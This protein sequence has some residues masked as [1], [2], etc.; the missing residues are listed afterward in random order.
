MNKRSVVGMVLIV[1]LALSL[2]CGP[3]KPTPTVEVTPEKTT[4]TKTTEPAPTK[5]T[6]EPKDSGAVTSLD[7]VK[8][9]T[10][11]IEAEGVFVD[12]QGTQTSSAGRGSGFIIDP[13]GIAVTNNHVVAGA[14]MLRVW[15]GGETEPRNAK[16]LG[17]SECSDLA[18]IDLEGN[19][20][21]YL[22]PYTGKATTGLDVYAAGFPLGDP[23]FT[24][25]RGII[26]K[27]RANGDTDWASVKAVLEHDAVINPGNSGGP[28]V[29]KD[30]E[31]VGVN[32]ASYR[33][34]QQSFAI[35]WS[36][37]ADIVEALQT[38]D[39][40]DSLGVNAQAVVLEDGLS[41]VWAAS[42]QPGSS[43]D[44]AGVQSGDIIVSLEN[45]DL[46]TDG[47]MADY[48]DILRTHAP[49]DTLNV[50][51]VR[52]ATE[53]MWAGQINGREL[54]LSF[55]FAQQGRDDVE[56]T[57]SAD[58][59]EEY[60]K[61]EDESSA[62]VMEVPAEWLDQDGGPWMNDDE[63][64]GASLS[65][66]PDLEEFRSSYGTPGVF[67][68]AAPLSGEFD[69]DGLLDAV[70]EQESCTYEGRFDYQ[71]ELY[72]GRYDYYT[73]C[74]DADSVM[75][76]VVAAPEEEDFVT[77]II[78]QAV[79]EADL[80]AADHVFNTF[81]VVG[82]L[83]G[84]TSGSRGTSGEGSLE[85]TNNSGT[86]I[87]NLYIASTDDDSWGSSWLD[88][89]TIDDGDS[90]VVE[91][92][93]A[94]SYDVRASD[95]DDSGIETLYNMEISGE[96]TWNLIPAVTLPDNAEVRFEDDFSDNHNNW[97]LSDTDEVD[98][99]D[100]TDGEFCILI[101]TDHM[102]AWEWYE[103][104]RTDEFFGEVYCSVDPDMD[105]SCGIGFGPDGDNLIWFEL[106]P[107]TQS[108]RLS[109]L[110][111]DDWQDPLLDWAESRWISPYGGNYLALGRVDNVISV[112]VNGH[113]LD[114]VSANIFPTGRFGIGGVAYDDSYVDICL[115]NLTVWH[116]K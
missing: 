98:Y 60:V 106:Y 69:A 54:A 67:F 39:D 16:L 86:D 12:P 18:V 29:T 52:F 26:S 61:I 76:V 73:E 9:A 58:T 96:M 62:I 113:M 51:V 107:S 99:Q 20:Y 28:L 71:D 94:G 97:G 49:D 77:V 102:T 81:T 89:D 33:E 109:L 19:G 70:G 44:K 87:A 38:D 41:G 104:F 8:S 55:S 95:S 114:S 34:A 5:D 15:V 37:A 91:G 78:M 108:Y 84:A 48:C 103:P 10:I 53:E 17:G 22:T 115:D 27:E 85:I 7:G 2:A 92:I 24:L 59:Y 116:L 101:K 66:A 83:P 112:Y 13:S 43:A 4:D 57:G 14:A 72:T 110:E 32:Y 79:T 105:A 50:A 80:E 64:L 23:E 1:T 30:G 56:D 74:G 11:Q 100:P 68:A 31:V 46:A 63:V 36:E 3:A 90:Y 82:T 6:P 40:V 25:T 88:G 93:P 75:F 35:A 47:T 21:S 111:D 45:I 42:V 65:A